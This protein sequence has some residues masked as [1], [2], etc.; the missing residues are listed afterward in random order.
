MKERLPNLSELTQQ[1]WD[2]L[3]GYQRDLISLTVN[4]KPNLPSNKN[5]KQLNNYQ[6]HAVIQRLWM[7]I[8][9]PINRSEKQ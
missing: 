3:K 8:K 5:W 1:F 9:Q 2:S 4:H 6:K 7:C